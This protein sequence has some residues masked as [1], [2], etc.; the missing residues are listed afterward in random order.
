MSSPH[1]APLRFTTWLTPGL[2]LELFETIAQHVGRAL[3]RSHEVSVEP[4]MSGPLSEKDDRFASGRTDVGFICPPSYLWLTR[5]ASP[6]VRLV[7]LAPVHDDPRNG[8]E[9]AYVSDIVVRRDSGIGSFLDLEGRHVGF[10]ER[11]SLSGFVSLLARLH[12]EGLDLDFFGELE[13]VGSHRRALAMIE[14]GELDGAAIDAN[15]LRSWRSERGDGGAPLASVDVLGPHPV[16]PVVVRATAGP[17]LADA[18]AAVLATS[19]LAAAV[20]PLGVLGF[21]PVSEGDYLALAPAVDRALALV[22]D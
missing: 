15:V 14:A 7:P 10:N 9:P 2:P 12:D 3:G 1:G 22:P 4:K 11:A 17:E 5:R 6:S 20:R 18:V 8:G 13:Q 16:Q 21:A 19:E